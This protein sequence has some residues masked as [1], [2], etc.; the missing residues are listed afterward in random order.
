MGLPG[1]PTIVNKVEKIPKARTT[2][3]AEL[4]E[5]DDRQG[6]INSVTK[7]LQLIQK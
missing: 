3:S 7:I 1:S 4:I 5:G 6:I 2:R